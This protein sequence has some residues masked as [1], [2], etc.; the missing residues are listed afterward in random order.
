MPLNNL[1]L[2]DRL[3]IRVMAP[4]ERWLFRDSVLVF[5]VCFAYRILFAWITN[6]S[7]APDEYFQHMEIAYAIGIGKQYI[8]LVA[9]LID[10]FRMNLSLLEMTYLFISMDMNRTWEWMSGYEIR[11]VV[12]LLPTA[13][14]FSLIRFMVVKILF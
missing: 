14:I 8:R 6:T 7:F 11:S 4:D 5:S 10:V 9:V 2:H 1:E 3:D 13:S 12:T